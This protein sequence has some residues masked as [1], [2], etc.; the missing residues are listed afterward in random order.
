MNDI[1]KMQFLIK[2]LGRLLVAT[3]LG[4]MTVTATASAADLY[5]NDKSHWLYIGC[6]IFVKRHTNRLNPARS[7]SRPKLTDD[8]PD[9]SRL[10]HVARGGLRCACVRRPESPHGNLFVPP[11]PPAAADS[12]LAVPGG[13]LPG[14]GGV[15]IIAGQAR[16]ARIGRFFSSVWGCRIRGGR[17][18]GS[19]RDAAANGR[20]GVVLRALMDGG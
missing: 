3:T 12:P 18:R 16:A 20:G 17:R 7:P 11:D 14:C 2:N 4:V 1:M 8:S 19:R 10:V 15:P 6:L 9:D 13:D 5:K